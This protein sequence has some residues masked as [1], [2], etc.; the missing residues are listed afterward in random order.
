MLNLKK[1]ISFSKAKRFYIRMNR[2]DFSKIWRELIK[3]KYAS[4]VQVI[5]YK[6]NQKIFSITIL[7][8]AFIVSMN[9]IHGSLSN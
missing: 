9:Q 8:L 6:M 2:L 1:R 5:M 4:T 3:V 7:I